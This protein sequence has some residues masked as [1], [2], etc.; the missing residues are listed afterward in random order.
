MVDENGPREAKEDGGY[1]SDIGE[2]YRQ[3][4]GG[5]SRQQLTMIGPSS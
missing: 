3:A 1:C 5:I 4:A 2:F